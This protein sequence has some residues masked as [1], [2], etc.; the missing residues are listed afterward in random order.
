[1]QLPLNLKYFTFSAQK[2]REE[3]RSNGTQTPVV[4]TNYP[5]RLDLRSPAVPIKNQ[6]SCGS[7]WAFSAMA[8]L[9]YCLHRQYRWQNKI[10]EQ[11]LVDCSRP[12]GCSG[13][14]PAEAFE[15]INRYFYRGQHYVLHL[16][17]AVTLNFSFF[18]FAFQSFQ[19][20]HTSV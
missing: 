6:G 1:M 15:V 14:W 19:L 12:L 3:V 7:C 9:D 18:F 5:N 4:R 10:S 13:G 2:V 16:Y 8:C 17:R 20:Y 11:Y